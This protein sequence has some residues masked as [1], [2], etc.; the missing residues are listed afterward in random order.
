MTHPLLLVVIL[1]YLTCLSTYYL[2][3]HLCTV[4]SNAW[5]IT[6]SLITNLN[7]VYIVCNTHSLAIPLSVFLPDANL[8]MLS[9]VTA[10]ESFLSWRLKHPVQ[11]LHHVC[12]F[13]NT[14]LKT[15]NLR[16]VFCK[17]NVLL[18]IQIPNL[19]SILLYTRKFT[20]FYGSLKQ[21]IKS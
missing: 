10:F 9:Q 13:V 20:R 4:Y 3:I 1:V 8:F 17:L 15:P 5:D 11:R 16:D 2:L 6:N 18:S 19:G 21:V 7:A 14:V 12:S